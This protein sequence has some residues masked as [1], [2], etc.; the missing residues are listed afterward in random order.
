MIQE[1]AFG[2]PFVSGALL[3]KLGNPLT[4][5]VPIESLLTKPVIA[6]VKIGVEPYV[7]AVEFAVTVSTALFTVTMVVPKLDACPASGLYVA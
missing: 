5:P 7:T 3:L 1:P 6:A 2:F 4:T